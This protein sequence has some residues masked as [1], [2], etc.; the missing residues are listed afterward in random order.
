MSPPRHLSAE[1]LERIK[2]DVLHKYEKEAAK[3]LSVVIMGQTGAGKS[4]LLN[5]LFGADLPTGDVRPVTKEPEAIHLPGKSGHSLTFWDM[6]GIGESVGADVDYMAMYREKLI[7][8]DVVIWA[9]HSDNRSTTYEASCLRR[10]LTAVGGTGGTGGT[11]GTDGAALANKLTFVMTKVDILTPPSWIFALHRDSG[12][13]AP[14]ARLAD[15]LAAKALHYEEVFVR[16]WA[17][18]LVS[19]TYNPGG[20]A[21]SDDRLGYDDYTIRYRGYVSAEVCQNYQRRFPAEAEVFARLRDNHRVLA[22]S[23]LFRFNLAQL[24]VAVVNK[25]GPGATARF[26][27][28]LGETE[29]LAEVPVDTMRGLGNFLIWD[30]ARKLLDLSDPTLPPKL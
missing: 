10:L 20:F 2:A 15:K 16:P 21:H 25:L 22:C 9:L 5:V 29:R 14:G 17:H 24:M 12:V 27:R 23:A 18:A 4:S 1:Q 8:C 30:G 26:R 7:G 3:P 11:D 28:L 19:T 6:P 13:F